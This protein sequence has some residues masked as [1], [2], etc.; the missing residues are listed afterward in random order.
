MIWDIP[1]TSGFETRTMSRRGSGTYD[2]NQYMPQVFNLSAGPHQL[3][4]RGR[5]ANALL[6]DLTVVLYP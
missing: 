5:E 6:R 4:L 1:L 2:N 3:I